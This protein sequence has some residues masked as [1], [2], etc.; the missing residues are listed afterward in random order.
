MTNKYIGNSSIDEGLRYVYEGEFSDVKNLII[1]TV[2]KDL[3]CMDYV[4]LN[5]NEEIDL[6]EIFKASE[7]L[8]R[9][10]PEWEAAKNCRKRLDLLCGKVVPEEREAFCRKT[11]CEVVV[12]QLS[13]TS[14]YH[15]ET[16]VIFDEEIKY[17]QIEF[18]G[19]RADDGKLRG[20]VA[21]V[22]KLNES[23]IKEMKYNEV[24]GKIIDIQADELR[25]KTLQQDR[26]NE[27][28]I[29][30]LGNIVERRDQNSGQH[31]NRVK[32]YTYVLAMQIMNDYPEYK[33]TESKVNI[34]TYVSP[35]HD[36][37]KVTIPDSILLKPG[38]LTPEEWEVMK[39]HC[40]S[41]C[42][43]LEPM[44]G[45]WHED[46]MNTSIEICKYHHEKWDG[47]GYPMGLIGNQIPISAQI[48]SVADCFDALTSKRVYKDAV[49][50]NTAIRMIVNGDC[51]EFS[52]KIKNCLVKCRDKLAMAMASSTEFHVIGDKSPAMINTIGKMFRNMSVLL[53]DN[54]DA[55]REVSRTIM[56]LEG[57][58][59]LEARSGYE[60]AE[61]VENTD[62]FDMIIMNLVMPGMS[63]LETIRAIRQMPRV[64]ETD[65]PIV[66]F[67]EQ[68][69]DKVIEQVIE[70]GGLGCIRKPL[71]IS[72]L[73]GVFLSSL[74]DKTD[75]IEKKLKDT[76][77]LINIDGLT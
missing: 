27:K 29:S 39:T 8:K 58:I 43:I 24:V 47:K 35:L 36:I 42:E 69:T 65:I 52:K 50:V 61:I 19:D 23:R 76:I 20:C 51:G 57:A 40:E 17:I 6:V 48:V 34:I 70:A 72:E 9:N 3:A 41:G 54:D 16:K 22:R 67:T 15:V 21:S 31:I 2:T 26:T 7:E 74:K 77:K 62:W 18:S 28:I 25:Q 63:G 56:E 75:Q 4:Y 66:G 45:A 53:V 44:K 11:R 12:E 10:I 64:F 1:S 68:V 49:D 5:A 14:V 55:S 30:L 33:L 71:L 37:G 60:A 13:N 32:R 46:Y 59:V 73:Y 38:K